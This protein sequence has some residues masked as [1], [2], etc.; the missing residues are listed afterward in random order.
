MR[1]RDRGG[2]RKSSRRLRRFLWIAVLAPWYR[3]PLL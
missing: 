3:A 1:E 2:A